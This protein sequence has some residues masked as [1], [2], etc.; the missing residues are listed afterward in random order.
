ML[1]ITYIL[2]FTYDHLYIYIHIYIGRSYIQ[3]VMDEKITNH[4]LRVYYSEFHVLYIRQ[5]Y[6]SILPK[7]QGQ[8]YY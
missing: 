6:I 4:T 3:T 1:M 2:W 7:K 8:N 5:V